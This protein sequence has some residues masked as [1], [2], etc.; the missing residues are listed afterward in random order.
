[1]LPLRFPYRW[2]FG[3]LFVMAMVLT[4]A[5]LPASRLTAVGFLTDKAAHFLAFAALMAWF[6]G[7]FRL[8]FT[9]L[10]GI[11]LLAFG[12][13]IELLQSMVPYRSA[14]FGDLQADGVGILTGWVLAAVGLRHW[15]R[16]LESLLLPRAAP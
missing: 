15:T 11:G 10:V 6:C 12:G 5:L 4:L 3:G 13:M 9:P 7:V 8:P 14:E 1:M 2:L 16:W